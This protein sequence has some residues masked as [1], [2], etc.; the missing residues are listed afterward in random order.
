MNKNIKYLATALIVVL[1]ILLKTAVISPAI[2]CLLIV[3]LMLAALV[4]EILPPELAMGIS[5][6]SLL[7]GS[8]VL[9]VSYNWPEGLHWLEAIRSISYDLGDANFL[10]S[11]QAFSG[12]S[13]DAVITIAVLFIVAAGVRSSGIFDSLAQKTLGEG[14]KVS[15]AILRMAV[16]LTR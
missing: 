3:A 6:G 13:D 2:F 16:L 7:T 5:L 1:L 14:K 11:K 4:T 12:F 9:G 8:F 10:T 15:T